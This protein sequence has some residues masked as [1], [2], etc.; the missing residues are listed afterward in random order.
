MAALTGAIEAGVAIPDGVLDLIKGNG[1][2]PRVAPIRVTE[3]ESTTA[4]FMCD[5]GPRDLPAYRVALT[6]LNGHMTVL[7]PRVECWWPPPGQS[8]SL[9]LHEA[10]VEDDDRTV[11]FPAF[12]G[13]LTEFLKAEFV[14]H[15][16]YVIGRAITQER[17]ASGAVVL[18]GIQRS[19]TGT[20]ATPLDGRVLV[21]ED[22]EPLAVTP[23]R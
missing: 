11:H 2:G 8:R 21:N 15:E 14:E 17:P 4:A 22:G 3:I 1:Q 23:A 19:V 7:D 9:Y 18:V 20:L 16:S 12:G 10:T 13:V 5:R 6:G